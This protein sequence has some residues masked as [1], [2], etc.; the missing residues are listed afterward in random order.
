MKLLSTL[1]FAVLLSA[2][3]GGGG[4]S[5]AQPSG[6]APQIS[7]L[8]LSQASVPYMQGNGIWTITGTLDFV[9]PDRDITTVRVEVSDGTSLSIPIP[10]PI[11]ASSGTLNGEIT[12]STEALGQ[13]T[14]QVWLV[15][16]A[17]HSSN[18]LL[19]SFAVVVDTGVWYER[20][21]GLQ[22]TLNDVVWNGSQFVAVGD[23]GVIL[24]SSD[25]VDWASQLSGTNENLNAI[26]WDGSQ[27]LVAGDAATILRSADGKD[28]VTVHAGLDNIWLEA[29]ASSGTRIVAAGQV[30][31]P[32]TSYMLTSVDGV[33]WAENAALVQNGTS[34][35]DIAWSGQQFVAATMV[36]AFPTEGRV[37]VSAD[38]LTWIDVIISTDSVSTFS[39][40]W[41]GSQFAAGGIVGRVFTSPDGLNWTEFRT[42]VSTNFLSVAS[43]GST[44]IAHGLIDRGVATTDGGVTWQTF[45]M[46]AS[47]ESRGMAWGANRFVSVG[48]GGQDLGGGAILTTR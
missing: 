21:S 13:F 7:N 18:R 10:G 12:I 37:M 33:N 16:Q 34:I 25:G 45:D 9:D 31:G 8:S 24:S 17:G 22:H 46:V 4:G 38:G 44:L 30:F 20:L 6:T 27:Y 42:P 11:P 39:I 14:A 2:C 48:W 29:V 19:M 26:T 32:N 1:L 41:D 3:G 43:S 5:G 15:D 36:Q 40:V 35:Y 23:G 28:W 47:Y